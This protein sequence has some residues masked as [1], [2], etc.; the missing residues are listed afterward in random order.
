MTMLTSLLILSAAFALGDANSILEE[1]LCPSG[2]TKYGSRCLMFVKT[3]RSWPEAERN[4]VSLGDKLVS[5]PNVVKYLGA[6]LS[7]VHSSAEEEFLQALV[8]VKTVG[9]PP[10]WIGG[11]IL[12]RTGGGS[13]A[14][15]L[16]LITR[17]G[18]KEGPAMLVP[19][20]LVFISTLEVKSAGTMLYVEGACPRCAP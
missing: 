12:L 4:C 13:G 15:A 3:T 1:D 14:M 10:T 8:L 20:R 6:N 9:F 16:T 5:V 2:W 19:E 11:F 18:Q 7:S 17:T